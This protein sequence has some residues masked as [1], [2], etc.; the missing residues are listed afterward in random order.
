MV[1]FLKVSFSSRTFKRILVILTNS[2]NCLL[3]IHP[4]PHH[5]AEPSDQAFSH[6]QGFVTIC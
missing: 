3:D 2:C 1:I 5:M 6:I 4:G